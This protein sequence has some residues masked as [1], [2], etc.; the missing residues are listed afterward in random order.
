MACDRI[1]RVYTYTRAE[2]VIGRSS[3]TNFDVRVRVDE[4]S[5]SVRWLEKKYDLQ[6]DIST[7]IETWTDCDIFDQRNWT[8]AIR[9]NLGIPRMQI[10]MRNGELGQNYLGED[11]KFTSKYALRT[12]F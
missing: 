4:K 9:D 5:K 6:G 3:P 7:D 2:P 1:E 8:C 12:D 10:E 11:R